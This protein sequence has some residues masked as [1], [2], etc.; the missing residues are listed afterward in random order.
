MSAEWAALLRKDEEAAARLKDALRV[1][2]AGDDRVDL[3][4]QT[5]VS[6]RELGSDVTFP[7]QGR[8][9][10]PAGAQWTLLPD[11]Y[12]VPDPLPLTSQMLA[13]LPP[14]ALPP[15][16]IPTHANQI[17]RGWARRLI[18]EAASMIAEREAY[19][20]RNEPPPAGEREARQAWLDAAPPAPGDLLLGDDAFRKV[21]HADGLGWWRANALVFEVRADG[22]ARPLDTT[23]APF[24]PWCLEAM[25]RHFDPGDDLELLSHIFDGLRYKAH[26]PRQMRIAPNMDSLAAHVRPIAED[27]SK[28]AGAGM[29]K[30]RPLLWLTGAWQGATAAW[31]VSTLPAWTAPVGG[32]DK[33]DKPNEKRRI[34]NGSWPYKRPLA[35]NHP[36]HWTPHDP[37]CLS[38]NELAGPMRPPPGS[39][40]N[41]EPFPTTPWSSPCDICG[42]WVQDSTQGE[43][44][45]WG[46]LLCHACWAAGRHVDFEPLKWHRERKHD[47]FTVYQAASALLAL[48]EI[49]GSW[50]YTITTDFRWWFWQFGTHPDE[51]WTSQFIA[52]V[53]LGDDFAVCLVGELVANMGRSP[54]SNIAS[55]VGSRLFEPIRRRA[56]AREPRLLSKESEALR[57]VVERRRESLGEE[58]ARLYWSGCYT[59][60]AF[61]IVMGEERAS[62]IATD[63]DGVNDEIRVM[64]ADLAKRPMGTYGD[65]I[66]LRLLANA[67]LGTITPNKRVRALNACRSMCDGT[68]SCAD[69]E[70]AQGLLGH[71]VAILALPRA[72]MNGLGR[73]LAFA[74]ANY[75]DKVVL[76][77]WSVRAIGEL[78]RHVATTTSVS[79]F[80]ALNA[81]TTVAQPEA[82]PAPPIVMSS[83][84][85]TGSHDEVT[86]EL[87]DPRGAPDPA[88]FVHIMGAYVRFPLR[89]AWRRVHIT[90]TESLGPA[91]GAI[92][93]AARFPHSEILVQA[94]ATA[95][96]AFLEGRS[97]SRALQRI[98]LLWR[99]VN[100]VLEFTERAT[101][102]HIAGRANA[103]DDAG[104]R[105]YWDVFFAYAAALSVKMFAVEITQAADTFMEQA[106]Y[107]A[108]EEGNQAP[109]TTRVGATR[110]HLAPSC[111]LYTSPSPRDS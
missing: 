70:E 40:V 31:P 106:L 41:T 54:V 86:G 84:A 88:I 20:F 82:A 36:H 42:A 76:T 34:S 32:V 13:R 18:F 62:L 58:Q 43:H 87:L 111:L 23:K 30:V 108:L 28:L 27:I 71:I 74:F 4:V 29:Y 101:C 8:P 38:F 6:M 16:P 72:L 39:E 95:A 35:W 68:L 105:G 33:K 53:K 94:D 46:R 90:V 61:T 103:F 57:G 59:D 12:A 3:Y 97:E 69:F 1:A 99:E 66:G 24:T 5:V 93:L 25:R 83:D 48:A 19:F 56:D 17:L 110:R 73:Q 80:V 21:S 79:I 55:S 85:C 64:L 37:P 98:Y 14:Q 50:L 107:V 63:I 109:P 96:I 11:I 44:A 52:I 89:G 92:V 2:A 77:D 81:S 100:G 102:Q 26:R 49:G 22:A 9:R 51:Y 78:E 65:H 7:A 75:H 67:A 91:L 104:S 60:D 15:G 45:W 10:I 47:A